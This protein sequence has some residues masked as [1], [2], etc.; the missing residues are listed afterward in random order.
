MS[1][2]GDA[3]ASCVTVGGH[4][5]THYLPSLTR[6]LL[7]APKPFKPYRDVSAVAWRHSSVG[8]GGVAA[9][10]QHQRPPPHDLHRGPVLTSPVSAIDSV[11]REDAGKPPDVE[12]GKV[13]S[14]AGPL[15]DV[16]LTF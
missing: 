15:V 14:F 5:S 7:L 8:S 9:I 6:S 10:G 1:T 16:S 12:T 11:C 3:D 2:K 13:L 4:K